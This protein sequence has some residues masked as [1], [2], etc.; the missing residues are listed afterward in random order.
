MYWHSS[1]GQCV[2]V[3]MYDLRTPMGSLVYSSISCEDDLGLRLAQDKAYAEAYPNAIQ[4]LTYDGCSSTNKFNCHGY[5]WIRVEQGIDRRVGFPEVIRREM[6]PYITDGSYT[7]VSSETFPAKVFWD[8]PEGIIV[9]HSAVTTQQPGWCISKWDA[10]PLCY[11]QYNDSPYTSTFKYYVRN[12]HPIIENMAI[13]ADRNMNSCG[14]ITFIN[15]TISNNATVNIHA[16]DAVY[17]NR[18]CILW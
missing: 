11:H 9:D 18:V 7:Q 2:A 16:Q 15:D 14:D 17:L 5:A 12:C 4:I 1:F 13:T 8:Y 6:P 10:G 3:N